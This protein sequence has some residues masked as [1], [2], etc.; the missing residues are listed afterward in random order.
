MEIHIPDEKKSRVIINTDAKNE[1]DDQ[2]AIVHAVLTPSFEMHGII[3]AHFGNRKSATSLKDSHDETMLLLRMMG[4]ENRFRVEDGAEHAMPDEKTPVDSPG[5]RLIIEEALKED[6]RPLYVA[7][8][9]PLTDMAS[10]LLIEPRI[11]DQN[12]KVIWIGGGEWPSGGTEY[13]LSNDIHAANV[14]FKSK[15]EVWQIPRN[16]YRLMPV[17]Y[18]ELL[19]RVHPHGEIGKYLV[20]Q[21]IEFNNE[22]TERPSE[23][24][25]L[26]DSPAVGA[27]IYPDCGRW[28][29]KPAPEFDQNMKYIHNGK[30]RSIKVY[31]TMDSRFILEDFYAKLAQFHRRFSR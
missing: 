8:Y 12:I 22:S 31:E 15:T 29:W 11:A 20:E 14:V 10:A 4:M 1:V 7:F 21:L 24:R 2:Y 5:A 30:N 18:A 6:K 27:I 9:G 3:P 26:G 19:E 28:S 17:G 13:N 16:V 25:V 23:Y